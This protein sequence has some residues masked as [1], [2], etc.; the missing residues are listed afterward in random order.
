M[1]AFLKDLNSLFKLI[2][3]I[4]GI[5]T[6]IPVGLFEDIQKLILSLHSNAKDLG[7]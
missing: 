6:K 3:R 7:E 1:C 4:D 2:Y 5:S